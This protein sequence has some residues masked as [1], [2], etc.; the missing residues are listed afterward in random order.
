MTLRLALW[1]DG[2]LSTTSPV[3][4][5]DQ[6]SAPR[7]V[8]MTSC[9]MPQIRIS[10]PG[11]LIETIPYLLGFHPSESLVLIG[12]SGAAGTAGPQQIQ[13]TMRVDLLPS[14][15]DDLALQPL[16]DA[17]LHS[18]AVGVAAVVI[19]EA[20]QGDPRLA[21]RWT[22]LRD[23]VSDQLSGAGITVYDVL[24]VTGSRWWSLC[25]QQ[26]ECC[27]PAGHQRVLGCSA[28]A[29]QATFAGMVAL[30]DRDALAA[31]LTGRQPSDRMALRARLDQAE[32]RANS[33]ALGNELP[34]L[35]SA[36]ATQVLEAGHQP[37][38]VGALTDDQ[39][40]RF[41]VALT[42]L[43]VRDAVWLAIDDGSVDA[44]ALMSDLHSRLP[45]PYDAAPLFLFGWAQWR[46][47][48]G[49]LAMMAAERALESD[50]G[51]SAALLLIT[52]VQR[53]L[54]PRLTPTLSEPTLGAAE[55]AEPP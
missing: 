3:P 24:M 11:E 8:A 7:L 40:A 49:T 2:K 31:T 29:A 43:A 21:P 36:Q 13:V 25:C 48:N 10:D 28:A 20:V 6:P 1:T 32:Q 15:I 9:E 52:A 16:V 17:L 4:V 47:G 30:P 45:A 37:E 53:G 27:P 5:L 19:T 33:A 51:Y 46:A 50:A 42:D 35:R 44:S 18:E 38:A 26:P 22:A 23:L 34:R 39:V 54:D 41:A 14:E 55:P 12:F